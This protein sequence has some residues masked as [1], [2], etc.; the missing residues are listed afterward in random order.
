[1]KWIGQVQDRGGQWQCRREDDTERYGDRNHH[2]TTFQA[3][4]PRRL[5]RQRC[6]A[7]RKNR[8]TLARVQW[9]FGRNWCKIGAYVPY[10]SKRV[11]K[12]EEEDTR[13]E[14]HRSGNS[15][16]STLDA[17]DLWGTRRSCTTEAAP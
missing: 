3:T 13:R 7:Y 11:G 10:E 9:E 16:E 6:E 15:G 8:L 4:T 12:E 5:E 17:A 1:M 2:Q 14:L